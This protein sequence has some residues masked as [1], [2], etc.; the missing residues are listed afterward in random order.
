MALSASL[1]QSDTAL[2]SEANG[3]RMS[4]MAVSSGLPMSPE[5]TKHLDLDGPLRR[6]A[7][8]RS[9]VSLSPDHA[10]V[11]HAHSA[12]FLQSDIPLECRTA[13]SLYVH[14][15]VPPSVALRRRTAI[16]SMDR[17]WTERDSRQ[18]RQTGAGGDTPVRLRDRQLGGD[19]IDGAIIAAAVQATYATP[20]RSE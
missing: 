13:H 6:I 8:S 10:T 2:R 7:Q 18:A 3:D 15:Q 5:R 16:G 17:P 9:R 20:R 4:L 19:Q 11:R 1:P 14:V 12:T